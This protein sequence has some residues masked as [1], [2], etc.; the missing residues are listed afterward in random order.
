MADA[1]QV[2]AT[3]LDR[4]VPSFQA[5]E[6]HATTIA[7]SPDQVWAALSQ[8]TMGELGLFRLLMGVRMLPG[9]LVRSPR[10][11]FAAEEPLLGWAVRSTTRAPDMRSMDSSTNRSTVSSE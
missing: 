8:V 11:R 6:R 4:I 1:E 9:R 10:A 2:A 7:A 5:S 3:A